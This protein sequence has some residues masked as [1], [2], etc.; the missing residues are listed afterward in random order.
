MPFERYK[1]NKRTR[2]SGES[3]EQYKTTLRKLSEACEFDTITPNEILRDRLIFGIHDTKVRERLLHETN[4]TLMKTD[5]ICRAAESMSEQ[6]RIV[7]QSND[8]TTSVH[9]VRKFSGQKKRMTKEA[10]RSI[11][12]RQRKSAG[13]AVANMADSRRNF[14]RLSGNRA[15][16]VVNKITSRTN[17]DRKG[18]AVREIL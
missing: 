11:K 7:G 18:R 2:E 15:I 17:V 1:F 3:Y 8:E 6:M 14:A 5:D 13:I 4:L 9:A 10:S 16:V 12:V